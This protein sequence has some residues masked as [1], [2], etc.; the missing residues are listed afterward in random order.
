MT[1]FLLVFVAVAVRMGVHLAWSMRVTVGVNEVRA[2]QQRV[3]VQYLRRRT[4]RDNAAA[5]EDVTVI[6]DVLHQVEIVSGRDHGL[7]PAAAAHQ[8]IDHLALALGIK[9]GGGLIQQQ[10]LRIEDQHRGQRNP[11]LFSRLKDDEANDLS[12]ARSPSAP[13]FR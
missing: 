2:Q 3:V 4:R 5:L 13:E 9:R 1:G 10:D 8:E 12:N 6:R 7:V 11:L